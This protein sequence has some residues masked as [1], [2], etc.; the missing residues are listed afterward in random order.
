MDDIPSIVITGAKQNKQEETIPLR[1][2]AQPASHKKNAKYK[3]VKSVGL[4]KLIS[5]MLKNQKHTK[6]GILHRNED[7][8]RKHLSWENVNK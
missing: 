6:L 4:I 2:I 3:K 5:L 8:L 7:L 1:L